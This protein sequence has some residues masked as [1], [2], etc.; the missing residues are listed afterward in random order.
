ME[1]D[2]QIHDIVI[3]SQNK[4]K[5]LGTLKFLYYISLGYFFSYKQNVMCREM[6]FR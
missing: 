1:V 3:E 6:L 4:S 2:K 5:V